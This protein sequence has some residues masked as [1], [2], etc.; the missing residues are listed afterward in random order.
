[1]PDSMANKIGPLLQPRNVPPRFEAFITLRCTSALKSRSKS[2]SKSNPALARRP[3]EIVLARPGNSRRMWLN[4]SFDRGTAQPAK[5]RNNL[6]GRGRRAGDAF[7][8]LPGIDSG[9]QG[10]S[11]LV[12][13]N[14]T[15]KS[16]TNNLTLSPSSATPAKSSLFRRLTL[17]GKFKAN[18]GKTLDATTSQ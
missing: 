12:L 3:R 7:L 6:P 1:M 14:R 16:Q 18:R 8:F 11:A 17:I 13:R 2:S 4:S 9:C 10:L 5:S 15:E